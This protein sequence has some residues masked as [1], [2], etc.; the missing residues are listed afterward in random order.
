MVPV[1]P[2]IDGD[3]LSC[4]TLAAAGMCVL[5]KALRKTY[6]SVHAHTRPWYARARALVCGC[7]RVWVWACV[8]HVCAVSLCVCMAVPRY[9][10]NLPASTLAHTH[11]PMHCAQML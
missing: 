1:A 4:A 11:A 7:V 10:K 5:D 6:Q 2:C 9:W 3:Q 8:L